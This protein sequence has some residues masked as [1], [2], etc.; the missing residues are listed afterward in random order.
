MGTCWPCT[1]CTGERKQQYRYE[2]VYR[3]EE[4]LYAGPDY[5]ES[6][7]GAAANSNNKNVET[8]SV[9]PRRSQLLPSGPST[10]EIL[11]PSSP[12]GSDLLLPSG[13]STRELILSSTSSS[14][15]IVLS[16]SSSKRDRLAQPGATA[17][18]DS[19]IHSG[20]S[21]RDLLLSTGLSSRNILVPEA[22][23]QSRHNIPRGYEYEKLS[24]FRPNFP[25]SFITTRQPHL[26][27]FK[28]SLQQTWRS[29]GY[30][31]SNEIPPV[32]FA[33][34]AAFYHHKSD[35]LLPLLHNSSRDTSSQEQSFSFSPNSQVFQSPHR[36]NANQP[37]VLAKSQTSL[38]PRAV[39]QSSARNRAAGSRLNRPLSL[40]GLNVHHQPVRKAN[41]SH[42]IL[43]HQPH[44]FKQ[45]VLSP[46]QPRFFSSPYPHP[47]PSPHQFSPTNN[48]PPRF[49]PRSPHTPLS[50]GP[51]AY[52]GPLY[53]RPNFPQGK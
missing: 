29:A 49:F 41:L 23:D 39:K 14:K 46:S 34:P 52:P 5:L 17:R 44:L 1:C 20:P 18:L 35:P 53:H 4:S 51:P 13:P 38:S 33:S 31:N 42:P 50:P 15:D 24:N 30:L 12:G 10:R 26:R 8:S 27:P 21:S 43:L 37:S 3:T 19:L 32:R 16:T 48:P 36:L 11:L 9:D 28:Q 25:H 6:L 7:N 45:Q 22:Y 47:L 40:P 2:V